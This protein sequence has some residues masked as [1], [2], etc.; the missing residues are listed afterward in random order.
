MFR[1]EIGITSELF[2]RFLQPSTSQ[3]EEALMSGFSGGNKSQTA[4][5]RCEASWRRKG[6]IWLPGCWLRTTRV[7]RNQR[8]DHKYYPFSLAHHPEVFL[9]LPAAGP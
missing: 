2:W 4:K 6:G 3:I 9:E 8:R 5:F 7:T 1:Q